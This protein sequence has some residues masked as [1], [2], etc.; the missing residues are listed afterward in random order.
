MASGAG[1]LSRGSGSEFKVL[2]H[3]IK[4]W[5]SFGLKQYTV[6]AASL[7]LSVVLYQRCKHEFRGQFHLKIMAEWLHMWYKHPPGGDRRS[8]PL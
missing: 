7:I 3:S 4:R 8:H 1:C 5:N 2:L 6:L